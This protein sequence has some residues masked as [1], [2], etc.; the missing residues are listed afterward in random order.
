MA[1][2]C[3]AHPYFGIQA[4]TLQPAELARLT[5]PLTELETSAAGLA[6]FVE[7]I[8]RYLGLEQEASLLLCSSLV[9]ILEIVDTIPP[10]AA[11][12]A[13]AIAAQNPVRIREAS[14]IGVAWA[15]LKAAHAET[16]VDAAWDIPPA[17]LRLSLAVGLSF[18]GRFRSSYR[19]ASK[20]LATLI[21]VPLPRTAQN[22]IALVDLLVAVERARDELKA[23]DAAMSAMLPIH[24]R[25][26]KT[27]FVLLRTVSSALHSL[28]TQPVAPRVDSVIE[29]ARRGLAR[30]YIDELKRL[31]NAL[32]Q[33]VDEV[34]L[35]LKVSVREAFQVEGRDQIP[36]RD[37]AAKVRVWRDTQSRFDEWRRLSHGRFART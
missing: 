28:A 30:D 31:S 6:G 17:P 32:V 35:A 20:L 19:Q 15:D 13:A 11:E 8:A 21:K 18:F 24:W 9:S 23:E 33:A 3:F 37:L 27:D 25:G 14:E 1:G 34:L 22:R 12:F 7:D 16:F 2:P 29:I 26:P 5:Q 10:D 36:L 4:V